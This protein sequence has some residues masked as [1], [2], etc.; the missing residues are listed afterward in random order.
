MTHNEITNQLIDIQKNEP[1][2]LMAEII[3]EV[4][5]INTV[6]PIISLTERVGDLGIKYSLDTNFFTTYIEDI[7]SIIKENPERAK[8]HIRLEHFVNDAS[9]FAYQI[10]L[11]NLLVDLGYFIEDE[12]LFD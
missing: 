11:Q 1:S 9:W 2:R 3:T 7:E 6:D 12:D 5:A 4:L 10:T 8:K